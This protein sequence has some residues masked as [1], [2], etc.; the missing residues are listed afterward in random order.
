[1][2]YLAR[3]STATASN[4]IILNAADSLDIITNVSGG[5]TEAL[6]SKERMNQIDKTEPLGF[7]GVDLVITG[8]FGNATN[9]TEISKL[10]D[11][12]TQNKT[13]ASY[14]YGRFSIS[15][16]DWDDWNVDANSVRGYVLYDWQF[17]REAEANRLSFTLK[18]RFNGDN[19]WD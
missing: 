16:D 7:V 6:A 15:Y 5:A 3:D 19:P 14:P 11:W 1:M 4:K 13:S 2:T 12:I 18:F 8:Y 10:R 9:N 17:S